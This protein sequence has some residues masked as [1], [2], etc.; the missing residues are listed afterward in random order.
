M[1]GGEG[2]LTALARPMETTDPLL[3]APP[4]PAK[5]LL[6][7]ERDIFAQLPPP[8]PPLPVLDIK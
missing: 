7:D 3:L 8:P 4:L 2:P 5:Y 1:C 6:D